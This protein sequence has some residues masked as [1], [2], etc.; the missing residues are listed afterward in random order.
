MTEKK[1]TLVQ[2]NALHQYFSMVAQELNDAGYTVQLVLKEKID[3]DWDTH[4]VKELLWKPAQQAI[5]RKQ[6]TTDLDKV[7]DIDLVYDHINRHLGEKFGISVP[8][9]SKE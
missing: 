4:K 9:P 8:F 7:K 6:S 3:L 5:V 2:N 1:R